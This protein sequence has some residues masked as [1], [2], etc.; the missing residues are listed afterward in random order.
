MDEVSRAAAGVSLPDEEGDA[1]TVSAVRVTSAAV[2]ASPVASTSSAVAASPVEDEPPA[3]SA[4]TAVQASASAEVDSE[5]TSAT[6]DRHQQLLVYS[7]RRKMPLMATGLMP[8]KSQAEFQA[9]GLAEEWQRVKAD[10][11]AKVAGMDEV[12]RAAAGVSLPDEE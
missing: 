3:A 10:W 2:S 11:Q 7:Y 12:S 4:S 5:P 6:Q 9:V 1:A 8:E